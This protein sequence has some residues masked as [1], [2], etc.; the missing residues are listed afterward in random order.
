MRRTSSCRLGFTLIDLVIAVLIIGII[1]AV[2]TPRF[3]ASV[4][5]RRAEAGARLVA[6]DLAYLR[7]QAI[8]TSRDVT[9]SFATPQATYSCSSVAAI[10]QANSKFER[11]LRSWAPEVDLQVD[12]G[13]TAKLS[14]DMRGRPNIEGAPLASSKISVSCG[15]SSWQVSV[16]AD[17]GNTFAMKVR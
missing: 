13:G 17:T 6:S 9:I 8:S 16:D 2:S 11:K 15:D 3:A 12:F 14:F 1:A 4:S 5:A 7:R 10:N